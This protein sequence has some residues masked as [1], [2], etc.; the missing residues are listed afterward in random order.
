MG[1]LEDLR[2]RVEAAEAAAKAAELTDDEKELARLV[3][4]EREAKEAAAAADAVRRANDLAVRLAAA[5]D[6]A[7]GRYLV[8]GIDLVKCF[9]LAKSPDPKKLPGG[10]VIIVREPAPEAYHAFTRGIELKKADHGPLFTELVCGSLIDPDPDSPAGAAL[11]AFC[12]RY[13]GAAIGAGDVVAK[14]GGSRIEADKRGR[15]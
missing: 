9:K 12:E 5:Q 11:R 13:P 10:G 8:D 14:M 6:T 15:T 1:M 2:A 4:R 3:E 7:G